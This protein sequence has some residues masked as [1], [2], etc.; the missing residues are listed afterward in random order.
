MKKFVVE[1][2]TPTNAPLVFRVAFVA[3]TFGQ[4]AEGK[5]TAKLPLPF[6]SE[7]LLGGLEQ[8]KYPLRLNSL[9]FERHT[10]SFSLPA[11]SS[12][13]LSTTNVHLATPFGS[14][15]FS[16]TPDNDAVRV[17]WTL[18]L[19]M[20]LVSTND[21]PAFRAFIAKVSD[22]TM[23]VL[24]VR[25]GSAPKAEDVAAT[26]SP[27]IRDGCRDRLLPSSP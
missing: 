7:E 20:Q 26:S 12:W 22:T 8:R 9:Q 23:Q 10:Y 13:D 21:Y 25:M 11:G 5:L 18:I 15:V 24:T 4:A 27:R 3:P 14:F 17:A 19:T 2:K 1:N 16:A 6:K